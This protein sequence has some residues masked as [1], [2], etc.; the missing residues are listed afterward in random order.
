[1]TDE[2]ITTYE[3]GAETVRNLLVD[4]VNARDIERLE[5]HLEAEHAE[6]VRNE[7]RA[8]N[9]RWPRLMLTRGDRGTDPVAAVWLPDTGEHYRRVGALDLRF[10]DADR[11]LGLDFVEGIDPGILAEAP[12]RAQVAEWES[13]SEITAGEGDWI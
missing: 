2:P 10:D 6:D 4:A 5:G 8:L 1:M 9:E 13:M 12:S 3:T 11:I 7:L